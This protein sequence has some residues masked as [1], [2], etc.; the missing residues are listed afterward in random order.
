V[1]APVP[2]GLAG[3]RVGVVGVLGYV[4]A[5]AAPLTVVG[6]VITTGFAVTG[7]LA[8][9]VAFAVVGVVLV[10][11]AAGYVAMSRHLP[12]A[13]AFYAYAAHGVGRATGVG[14]AWVSLLSYNMLQVALYGLVG[15]ATAPLLSDAAGVSLPWWISALAAWALV[16]VLGVLRID[17]NGKVLGYLLLGEVAVICVYDVAWLTHPAHGLDWSM[18]SPTRLT[19]PGVGA[20]LALAVLGFTGFETAPVLSEEVRSPRR[21]IPA[22]T[23]ASIGVIGVLYGGSAWAMAAATGSDQIVSASAG[24]GP[25]L[26]FTLAASQLGDPAATLGRILFAT[27][28]LAAMI[29]FHGTSSRYTFA[30]GREHVLPGRFGATS[31]TGAPKAASLAQSALGLTVILIWVVGG[32]DPVTTLFYVAGTSGALGVLVLLLVVAVSV[33]GYFAADRRGESFW[34]TVI[35]PVTSV[36]A[37]GVVLWLVLANFAGL[38]GVTESSPLRWGIPLAYLLVGLAG[39]GYG[40]VL[41]ATRPDVYAAIGRGARAGLPVPPPPFGQLRPNG[42]LSGS[43][44]ATG[45][46]GYEHGPG[47]V[48][49][50]SEAHA[51][52][53]V[54][55]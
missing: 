34:H 35:A 9:P 21:T 51:D 49:L 40:L 30:L 39:C 22:A 10:V 5:S 17:L 16:A 37:L 55:E 24:E 19:G 23:Y 15:S 46:S 45:P 31:R 33:V 20:V 7:V 28:I 54:T 6:G 11:F 14:T 2:V 42:P 8:F 1:R 32:W 48:L 38:I 41:K 26:P 50:P 43:G 18:L 53:A 12:H 25:N 52:A 44:F 36:I 47:A 13:G 3:D 29:S 27:S 4:M